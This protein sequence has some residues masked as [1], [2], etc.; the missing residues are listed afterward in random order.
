MSWLETLGLLAPS[1][2]SADRTR[3]E[4][5][6]REE[7]QHHLDL[8]A[9]AL[10]AGGADP[11]AAAREARRR[12]GALEPVHRQ[13]LRH[14]LGERIM[15]HRIHFVLTCLLAAALVGFLV[16]DHVRGKEALRTENTLRAQVEMLMH[17]MV[18][19][20][21]PAPAEH[22]VLQVGDTVEIRDHY[23]QF[24][25][26]TKTVA[27]DGKLL[28]PNAGWVQVAGMTREEAETYITTKLAPFYM[29]TDVTLEVLPR[30]EA[31]PIAKFSNV[32]F[33]GF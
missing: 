32:L 1:P 4:A 19:P 6:V 11:E 12:F 22:V 26:A 30:R 28:V 21:P 17:S 13:C 29:K 3:V 18:A 16:K 14:Q 9:A 24:V 10:V 15:L 2:A 27:A 5:E 7:L 33:S 25:Q 20:A 23:N 31:A 8:C